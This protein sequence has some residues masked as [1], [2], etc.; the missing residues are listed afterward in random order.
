MFLLLL[1]NIEEDPISGRVFLYQERPSN[2][3]WQQKGVCSSNSTGREFL[4]GEWLF[5]LQLLDRG[6]G[7]LPN[8]SNEAAEGF[9]AQ[10]WWRAA[11][12]GAEGI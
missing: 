1:T 10:V 3:L 6:V 8:K 5:N 12:E 11:E 2:K 9:I 7:V 4:K